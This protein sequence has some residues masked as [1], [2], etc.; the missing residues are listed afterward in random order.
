[1]IVA[2]VQVTV[3]LANVEKNID[4]AAHWER[5]FLVQSMYNIP[6]KARYISEKLEKEAEMFVGWKVHKIP[7]VVDGALIHTEYKV[8]E[9]AIDTMM[10]K[11]GFTQSTKGFRAL[12]NMFEDTS[13]IIK[14]ERSGHGKSE[15]R[16]DI[17]KVTL[18][19]NAR[20]TETIYKFYRQTYF[21]CSNC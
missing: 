4:K 5:R 2:A 18:E 9:R 19:S 15:K 6:L 8:N 20:D 11:P 7:S 21:D 17:R 16:K 12:I 10:I 13:S 14:A 1:M 3:G